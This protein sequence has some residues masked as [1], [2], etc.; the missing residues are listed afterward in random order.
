MSD[1][2]TKN[3]VRTLH[4]PDW[5]IMRL[6]NHYR[7]VVVL[8][9]GAVYFLA[10]S[11][12]SL[13]SR[14]PTLFQITLLIYFASIVGS[15]Y[16]CHLKWPNVNTQFYLQHYIDILCI[17]T[18]L[19]ASG[20][21]QSGVGTLL[22]INIALL[23]QLTTTRH[24]LLFAAIATSLVLSSELFAGLLY[25]QWA[26][27]FEST[28]LLGILLF[29]VAWLMTVPLRR[30]L[31]REL[32]EPTPNR[33]AL[34]A[35]EIATLNEE[36]IR[37][38]DSGVLVLNSQNQVVMINDMARALIG[39]EFNELPIHLGRL[40]PELLMN[41]ETAQSNPSGGVHSFNV[42][43]TD[44]DIL[45]RYS[46][47]STSGMLIRIDDHSAIRQQFQQLKMAS[48]G[49]LSASIAHEIR[50]PLS[51]I[52]HATQLLQESANIDDVDQQLLA[53]AH[54]NTDRINRIIEDILQL[55]NRQKTRRETLELGNL[56]V[57]FQSRFEQ[58]TLREGSTIDLNTEPDLIAVF[59]P[60]HLDQ[61][62][63]NICSNAL[64][65]NKYNNIAITISAYRDTPNS[66]VIDIVDNGRGIADL[67][68]QKLFEPF[69]STHHEGCGLGLYIIRE[70]C[71]LN[72]AELIC[73]D[74]KEG[75]HFRV[76]LTN[77]QQ[78]AA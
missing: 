11:Q 49:R 5:A 72:K 51:A 7:L 60:L 62:L 14:V 21:I 76:T 57:E 19:Y 64:L 67:D 23:S 71:E 8:A 13:G 38:L 30:L 6:L 56:L 1:T 43:N 39:A 24:A 47:L 66:T 77:T 41:L 27:D 48:L 36:I 37:E 26:T 40:C 78:M 55:S 16:L 45:P 17:V 59:D 32:T 73:V 15:V 44:Q 75:A 34:D 65:H 70:L 31:N 53:I 18:L 22:L 46:P 69:Y 3:P 20:G 58:E 28:A 2:H 63:W 4:A 25:G 74:I 9:L 68:R 29:V 61:V 42:S 50:N 54:N 35:E 33:A 12:E 10:G 52:S